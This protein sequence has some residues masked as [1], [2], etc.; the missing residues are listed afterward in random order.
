IGRIRD[1]LKGT[2]R[3]IYENMAVM[4]PMMEKLAALLNDLDNEYSRIKNA[5]GTIDYNDLEHYALECLQ[6]EAGAMYRDRFDEIFVDEYQDSNQI[7]E[8][9]INLVSGRNKNEKN[10]FMV[11]D[12]KQ[13]IYKFRQA[14]P[15]LFVGKYES[16]SEDQDCDSVKVEL[17]R[18]YRSR[19][20]ILDFANYIFSR[21]MS[22]NVGDIAYDNNV[23]LRQGMDYPEGNADGYPVEIK[24]VNGK[25]SELF[26]KDESNDTREAAAIGA[27]IYKLIGSGMRINDK[28][29]TERPVEYRDITILNR[30]ANSVS[31]D[32]IRQLKKMGIPV[33]SGSDTDFFKEREIILIRSFLEILDNPRRDIPL[34]AVMRS[35]IFGFTDKELALIRCGSRYKNYYDSLISFDSEQRLKNKITGFLDNLQKYRSEAK[36]RGMD[37]LVWAIIHE[38]GLYNRSSA[39]ENI[40]LKQQNLRRFFEIASVY[41]SGRATGLF[42]FIKY[43]ENLRISGVKG[44]NEPGI[45]NNAVNLMS[46]HKSKGLEFPVVI[47]SG[48]GKRFNKTDLR[49][50]LIIDKEY[51]FGPDYINAEEGYKLTT[52]MKKGIAIKKD[53]EGMAEEMRVLY[54]ALTRAREKLVI[55]SMVDNLETSINK[56]QLRSRTRNGK[57][58]PGKV[59]LASGFIDWI[60]PSVINNRNAY[61]LMEGLCN[62]QAEQDSGNPHFK[63]DIIEPLEVRKCMDSRGNSDIVTDEDIGLAYEDIKTRFEWEYPYADEGIFHKKV[64]VTEIKKLRD[65]QKGEK[66]IFGSS[67][68]PVPDFMNEKAGSYAAERGTMLHNAI[69]AVDP[70][71]ALNTGYISSLFEKLGLEGDALAIYTE[72]ITDFFKSGLGRRML[73]SVKIESEKPFLIPMPTKKLYPGHPGLPKG[74]HSTLVQGVID[75]MFYESDGIVIIDYKSDNVIEGNEKVHAGRYAVQLNLYAEAVEKLTGIKVKEKYIYFLKN[76]C[77]VLL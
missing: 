45:G 63:I 37:K 65:V 57:I 4:A 16:Y 72:L 49:E 26:K 71:L 23:F 60:M 55:T 35:Q 10:V 76:R 69:A 53:I 22:K 21:I 19:V 52:A 18:N 5:E 32:Y 20:P 13:S 34:L 14:E 6:S 42:G 17:F 58:D 36:N 51:G 1:R 3:Q 15:G 67:F 73:K 64:S 40:H 43:L 56:W 7:Q 61:V 30:S 47:L 46:I 59:M 75:C 39:G 11:G 25:D 74:E 62:P 2:S 54:V 66:D 28:N 48:C 33:Y 38:T 27:E 41:E 68:V 8:D 12:V 29:G 50:K 44:N 70:A 77:S 31:D 9:I 24:L